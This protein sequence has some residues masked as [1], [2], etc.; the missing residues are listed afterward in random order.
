M[1]ITG[2]RWGLAG[3]EAVLKLHALYATGDFDRRP[4]IRRRPRICRVLARTPAIL[5]CW[6]EGLSPRHL[7]LA[8]R[9]RE[10]PFQR[11]INVPGWRVA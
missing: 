1:D 5:I 2:A 7:I 6:P 3:A 9:F 11:T 4:G 10:V 8:P